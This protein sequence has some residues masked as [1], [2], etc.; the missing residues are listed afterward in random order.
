MKTNRIRFSIRRSGQPKLKLHRSVEYYYGTHSETVIAQ[1]GLRGIEERWLRDMGCSV[2]TVNG[3]EIRA[4]TPTGTTP[5]GW[6][7]MSAVALGRAVAVYPGRIR[8]F[9]R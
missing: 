8:P 4:W 1:G 6:S 7:T 5:I 2:R 3:A 9:A